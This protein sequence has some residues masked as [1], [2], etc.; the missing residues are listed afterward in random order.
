MNIP[1]LLRH[2]WIG[3]SKPP[4]KWI[5]T[6]KEK[7]PNWEYSLF[8]DADFKNSK[9]HNQ[10]LIDFYYNKSVWHGVSDLIRYEL[11]YEEGGFMPEADSVCLNNVEEL[12][13]EDTET[14]YTVYENETTRAGLVSPILASPIGAPFLKFII[15]DLHKVK[16]HELKEPWLST[17]NGYLG[18]ILKESI[19]KVK[20]F[21]SHY[22]IPKHPRV[23]QRYSGTDKIYCEQM[24]GTS[25]GIYDQGR[26]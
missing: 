8:S 2:I 24:W 22:F 3:P 1:S 12:F 19:H 11:L 5:N 26:I 14:C 16:P 17:G 9:F 15:D 6:W 23:R 4:F 20:V 25:R 7:H 13:T 18:E 21:P 10:H